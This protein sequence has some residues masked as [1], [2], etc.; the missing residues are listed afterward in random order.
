MGVASLIL[1]FYGH[2]IAGLA[3][4]EALVL[5]IIGILLIIAEV[6]VVGGILG[7]LGSHSVLG[8]LFMA[9]YDFTQMAISIGIALVVALVAEV[10]LFRSIGETKGLFNKLVL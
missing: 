1:F 2:I 6:F 4:M 8:S 3:G 10:F 5:L 9:G 7:I